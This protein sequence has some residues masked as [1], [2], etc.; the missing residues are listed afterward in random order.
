MR[1]GSGRRWGIVAAVVA[2]LALTTLPTGAA[3]PLSPWTISGTVLSHTGLPI[4]GANVTLVHAP[5]PVLPDPNDLGSCSFV[6]NGT[7]NATGEF[8]I[9]IPAAPGSYWLYS[10]PADGFG[11]DYEF[12][13]NLTGSVGSIGLKVWPYRPYGNATIVLP[14]YNRLAAYACN[15]QGS[16]GCGASFQ[17][18]ILSWTADGATYVNASDDLV[19]YDF[20][21]GTTRLLSSA[22]TPLHQNIMRYGGV[23]NT[24]W[25]TPDGSYVYTVGCATSC[26]NSSLLEFEA[27]NVSTGA[28][29][30]HVWNVTAGSTTLNG[31]AD[32]IGLDGADDV[33]VL[34]N[35]SGTIHL[36]NLATDREWV[37]G[38]LQFFEANNVYWVPQLNSFIDVSAGGTILDRVAQYRFNGTGFRPVYSAL[39]GHN[40][41]SNFVNGLVYNLTAHQIYFEAGSYYAE[42]LV[43]DVL[44]VAPNGTIASS[45]PLP[46]FR[47]PPWPQRKWNGLTPMSPEHRVATTAWDPTV[48]ADFS[49]LFY[50]SSWLQDPTTRTW[51]DTNQTMDGGSSQAENA[52]ETVDGLFYNGTYAIDPASLYC[53]GTGNKNW[54]AS[55]C[56]LEGTFPGTGWGTIWWFWQIGQ[57]M[58]PF[59]ADSPIAQP[60]PPAAPTVRI[61]SIGATAVTINWT[62]PPDGGGPLLNWTVFWGTGP[63]NYTDSS[64]VVPWASSYEVPG[65][66]AGT[67]YYFGVEALNH[68]SF[69]PMGTANATPVGRPTSPLRAPSDLAVEQLGLLPQLSWRN[70][71]GLLTNTTVYWGAS[72]SEL[73]NDA[74]LPGSTTSF[75]APAVP[76][77][78]TEW[79]AV[80][81]W[82]SLGRSGLSNCVNDTPP[83]PWVVYTTPQNDTSVAIYLF[84]NVSP[85]F[86]HT[87]R[88][89]PASCTAFP[90]D[91]ATGNGGP[92]AYVGGLDRSASYCFEAASWS[93]GGESPWSPPVVASTYGSV[94]GPPTGVAA[95]PDPLGRVVVGWSNPTGPVLND[96]V[97]W[98]DSCGTLGNATSTGGP[99]TS[100]PVL[101]VPNGTAEWF[102]VTAWSPSG[103]SIPSPCVSDAPARPSIISA[104]PEGAGAIALVISDN[105]GPAYNHSILYGPL[106]CGAGQFER[107]AGGPSDRVLLPGLAPS[108]PYCLQVATWSYG[109]RSSYSA[110]VPATTGAA[111][112][113]AATALRLLS[114]GAGS[115]TLAWTDPSTPL[116]N[117]TVWVG[118]SCGEVAPIVNA[119]PTALEV[120]VAGLSASTTYCLS[121]QVWNGSIAAPRTAPLEVATLAYSGPAV[122]LP[123]SAPGSP[124]PLLLVAG[125]LAVLGIVVLYPLAGRGRRLPPQRD[126]G[127]SDHDRQP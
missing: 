7:T 20:A 54:S 97:L 47:N 14:N 12:L 64:S 108:T 79:Y 4:V 68:H 99:T 55:Y 91:S 89:G 92:W 42:E 59:P 105:G 11:G 113:P 67:K 76:N 49:P 45:H 107:S 106:P 41:A 86:D 22:W 112:P 109:G 58:F 37:G 83:A 90:Y 72:C 43:T 25:V 78:T 13:A 123:T 66:T 40:I 6:A 2:L 34:I 16:P 44:Q 31:Q 100:W 120:T 95:V 127:R 101:G 94:P 117:A 102:A 10:Q 125:A 116:T 17:V 82:S 23:E 80:A 29:V 98:G 35:E 38:Q 114:A 75:V 48:A 8:T 118:R 69:G 103:E 63:G 1:R 110:P 126:A 111:A 33:A 121:V 65:L 96:T 88:Y 74:S 115:L 71:P 27:V 46:Q 81:A 122:I 32:L 61:G 104:V 30:E 60:L 36:W 52:P 19:F 124:L 21:N 24:Q 87:V 50:N 73:A 18:P 53:A 26:D 3:A 77:G 62:L 70:P 9:A 51:F 39:W 85:V 15:G 119:S 57:P 84:D 5:C 28:L 93:Y 56:P